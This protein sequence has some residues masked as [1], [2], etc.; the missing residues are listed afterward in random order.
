[1]SRFVAAAVVGVG[2]VAC[3]YPQSLL[4]Q[5]GGTQPSAAKVAACSLLPKA[6][7]KKHLPWNDIVD[8]MEPEE[9]A[10]GNYGSSCN[11]PS[12]FIQILPAA[13][14][15]S[16]PPQ[17]EGLAPI[18]GVGEAAWFRNNRDRYAELWVHAANHT[19]TLQANVGTGETIESVKPKVVNLAKALIAKL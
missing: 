4:A 18:G 17:A 10:I 2:L 15:K 16:Q 11:Y 6:E 3:S 14:N 5:Q 1:V 12:V 7:V 19:V 9:E 13:R 8:S